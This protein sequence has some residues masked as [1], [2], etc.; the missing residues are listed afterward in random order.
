ML[1]STLTVISLINHLT[2]SDLNLDLY[3]IHYIHTGLEFIKISQE[4]GG[5]SRYNA[6]G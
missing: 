3:G 5:S 4:V 1:I 6:D 2:S